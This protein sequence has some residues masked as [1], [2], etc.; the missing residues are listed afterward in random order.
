MKGRDL[1][2]NPTLNLNRLAGRLDAGQ[3]SPFL[4]LFRFYILYISLHA[5]GFPL[6]LLF[7]RRALPPLRFRFLPPFTTQSRQQVVVKMRQSVFVFLLVI[8][9]CASAV[10]AARSASQ[11]SEAPR[12]WA[13]LVAGS[14]T[15]NNYR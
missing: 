2:R 1:V 12:T 6:S 13:L 14:D 7:L 8:L 4:V 3:F 15:Y 11:A 9:A 10:F 5:I